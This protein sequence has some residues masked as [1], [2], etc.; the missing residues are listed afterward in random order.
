MFGLV[1]GGIVWWWISLSKRD[2]IQVL[3][4]TLLGFIFLWIVCDRSVWEGT[5]YP[6]RIVG[7]TIYALI[8][9]LLK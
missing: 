6:S 5:H 9:A 8:M 7:I 1:V 2:T 4:S 3:N